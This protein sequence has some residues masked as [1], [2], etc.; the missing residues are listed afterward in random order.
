MVDLIMPTPP[1]KKELIYYSSQ[2]LGER[3]AN[4]EVTEKCSHLKTKLLRKMFVICCS[5]CVPN[6]KAI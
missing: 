3:L 5:T 2:F 6:F 1:L 4:D